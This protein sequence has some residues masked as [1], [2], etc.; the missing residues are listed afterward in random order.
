MKQQDIREFELGNHCYGDILRVNGTDYD[1]IEKEDVLEFILDMLRND[2]N[3][4]AITREV[5]KICLENLQFVDTESNDSR[6]DQCGNYN[7]HTKYE[8]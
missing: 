4:E 3:S 5:F 7:E 2:I 8:R 1:E 6:C